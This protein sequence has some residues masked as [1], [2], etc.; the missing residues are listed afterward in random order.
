MDTQA[1]ALRSRVPLA[2]ERQVVD[3]SRL[4]TERLA[5][6]ALGL[7]VL[8]SAAGPL[9]VRASEVGPAATAFHRF[10]LALPVLWLW[11]RLSEARGHQGPP[12]V[13]ARPRWPLVVAGV[14]LAADLAVWHRA[15][16]LTSVANAALLGNLAPVFVTAGLWLVLGRRPAPAFLAALGAI[17]AGAVLL[18]GDSLTLAG[19][20]ARGD[21]LALVAAVLYAGY[22]LATQRARV[23]LST[24]AVTLVSTAVSAVA[25]LPLALASG[26][27]VLPATAAGW[28]SLGSLAL[29]TQVAGQGLFTFALAHLPAGLA[30]AGGLLHPVSAAGLAWL[31]VGEPLS[32]GQVACGALVLGG[33]AVARR[34]A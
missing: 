17:V 7:A 31:V 19:G 22:I 10:A 29:L 3:G 11:R 28:L 15:L 25:L 32:M 16:G 18:L 23:A 14:C 24:P 12:V 2:I 6:G 20:Q 1:V 34:S 13:A 5:L 9:L 27:T 33:L 30:A 4:R 8:T 26:E 21:A